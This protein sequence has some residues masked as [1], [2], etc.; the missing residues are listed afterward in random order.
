[1]AYANLKFGN[2]DNT[3]LSAERDVTSSFAH[4][5]ATHRS[6]YGSNIAD[7]KELSFRIYHSGLGGATI[8]PLKQSEIIFTEDELDTAFH[9]I[10]DSKDMRATY[11][12]KEQ[13]VMIILCASKCPKHSAVTLGC[14]TGKT[15]GIM[16]VKVAEKIFKKS[17]SCIILVVPYIVLAMHHFQSLTDRIGI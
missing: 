13:K 3:I 14:G 12:C 8:V 5:D 7:G 1:M 6:K 9:Y 11:T 4:S 10:C 16:V 15:A 17:V 2:I